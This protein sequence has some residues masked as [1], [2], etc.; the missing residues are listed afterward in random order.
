[1]NKESE[2]KV[3]NKMREQVCEECCQIIYDNC[4]ACNTQII[5]EKKLGLVSGCTKI[6]EGKRCRK[7]RV[8]SHYMCKEHVRFDEH[9]SALFNK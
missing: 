5:T 2:L 8:D 6:V 9:V 1:M 7:P 4:C 3:K